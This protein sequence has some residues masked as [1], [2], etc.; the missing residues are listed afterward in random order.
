MKLA[1][2]TQVL[3]GMLHKAIKPTEPGINHTSSWVSLSV[4]FCED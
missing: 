2:H 3:S 1:T 4:S